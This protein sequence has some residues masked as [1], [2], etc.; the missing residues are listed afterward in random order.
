MIGP[1]TAEPMPRR[2][3][4]CG[5]QLQAEERRYHIAAWCPAPGEFHFC[6]YVRKIDAPGLWDDLPTL[7]IAPEPTLFEVSA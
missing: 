4:T 1:V 2:C 5:A 6:R 3:P 7:A